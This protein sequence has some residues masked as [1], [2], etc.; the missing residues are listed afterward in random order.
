MENPLNQ[1][2]YLT[3]KSHRFRPFSISRELPGCSCHYRL[4]TAHLGL[5]RGKPR[6][7][8]DYKGLHRC[9]CHYRLR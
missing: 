2:G 1:G 9:S 4:R 6:H 8:S 7:L 5:Y 3:E